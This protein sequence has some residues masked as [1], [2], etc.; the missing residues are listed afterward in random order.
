[1]ESQYDFSGVKVQF[2]AS[3]PGTHPRDEGRFG[4]EGLRAAILRLDP[5]FRLEGADDIHIES[6]SGSV[7]R[8]GNLPWLWSV[9]RAARG[10]KA[11][12]TRAYRIHTTPSLVVVYPSKRDVAESKIGEDVCRWSAARQ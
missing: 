7:G 4:L 3:Q 12:L 6:C 1:V 5:R 2:V 8:V 9:Y 10:R 11:K